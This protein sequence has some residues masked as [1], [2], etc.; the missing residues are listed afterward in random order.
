MA[1]RAPSRRL[2]WA[3]AEVAK[4]AMMLGF[5]VICHPPEKSDLR[6]Y[7]TSH[8]TREPLS[9]FHRNRNIVDET[10]FLIA[11]PYQNSHQSI[12]GTWYTVDYALKK[13][14]QVKI[15]YPTYIPQNDQT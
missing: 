2:C 6:A 4:L 7:R 13:N 5:R 14:K 8:E 1:T 11:V 10:D 12:G 9:Y 15:F 3:D